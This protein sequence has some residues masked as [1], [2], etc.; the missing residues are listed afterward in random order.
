MPSIAGLL[1]AEIARAPDAVRAR[2][3]ELNRSGAVQVVRF[4]P[5]AVTAE[6]DGPAHRVE[7]TLVNGT[8]HW[9]CTCPEGRAGAFCHHCVAAAHSTPKKREMAPNFI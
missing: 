4:G 2:G 7:F 6:V 5:S 3:A 8:L 9:F 1:E